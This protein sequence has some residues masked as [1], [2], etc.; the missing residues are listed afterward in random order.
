MPRTIAALIFAIACIAAP[1]SVPAQGGTATYV[2]DDKG[3]LHAVIS[4]TGEIIVYEYDAAGN[5]TAIRPLAADG[6][7]LLSFSPR[8]GMPGAQ[9]SFYGVGFSSG[10]SGVSFKRRRRTN[11]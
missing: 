2:Y 10:V 9:V 1:M 3:R 7:E 11:H 8:E 6:L 5:V 4:V